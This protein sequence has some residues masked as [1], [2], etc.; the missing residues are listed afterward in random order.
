MNTFQEHFHLFLQRRCLILAVPAE[1][2]Q[3]Y[4]AGVHGTHGECPE[5]GGTEGHWDL[6]D[7]NTDPVL[8]WFPSLLA[9]QISVETL[10]FNEGKS[11]LLL[12]LFLILFLTAFSHAGLPVVEEGGRSCP[13]FL[14]LGVF[15]QDTSREGAWL[16]LSLWRT[17]HFL[18]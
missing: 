13:T 17:L 2:D 14:F 11:V 9:R 1:V 4:Q 12:W 6:P 15:F 5:E 3:C 8:P 7:L 18:N 10:P 16:P